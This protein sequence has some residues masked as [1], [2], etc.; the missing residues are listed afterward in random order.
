MS[1]Y[2]AQIAGQAKLT[3][4]KE[5]AVF[6]I[7]DLCFCLVFGD[8]LGIIASKKQYCPDIKVDNLRQILI[9][10]VYKGLSL[11]SL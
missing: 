4:I 9:I 11:P 5:E 8:G 3:Y 2:I 7:Q 1:P 6:Q 10:K